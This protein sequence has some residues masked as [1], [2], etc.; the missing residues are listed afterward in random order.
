MSV[1][2]RRFSQVVAVAFVVVMVV[3]FGTSCQ[4]SSEPFPGPGR[5][6][7][8]RTIESNDLATH[9]IYEL[10]QGQTRLDLLW[11]NLPSLPA[12]PNP[13]VS[14]DG[15][16]AVLSGS[17]LFNLKTGEGNMHDIGDDGLHTTATF[18]PDGTFLATMEKAGLT[19]LDV[20][21][22][23]EKII[24]HRKCASY[25]CGESCI[26]LEFPFWIDDETILVLAHTGY[27]DTEY[28]FRSKTLRCDYN[29]GNTKAVV[30][31]DNDGTVITTIDDVGLFEKPPQLK[32][33]N[34]P[35]LIAETVDGLVWVN[36]VELYQGIFNPQGL[37][38]DYPYGTFYLLPD[39]N[40]LLHWK[41][42][43]L[44]LVELRT[45]Q[46]KSLG[47]E[48]IVGERSFINCDSIPGNDN[49]VCN[50]SDDL[51]L[52][53]LSGE[54]NRILQSWEESEDMWRLLAWIP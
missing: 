33:N 28:S 34:G 35:T 17:F 52:L 9:E 54:K 36:T 46:T 22:L 48:P 38:L 23:T 16:Y 41:D 51:F 26:A 21:T 40:Q 1:E 47:N 8:L 18:S 50:R 42:N 24:L 10:K 25:D 3:L 11:E 39:G 32:P 49:V 29:D 14:P 43:L 5:L 7:L 13:V 12:L 15:N 2:V 4:S 53:S 20:E 19:L 27:I 30:V 31:L 6:I 45:G 44:E 37:N